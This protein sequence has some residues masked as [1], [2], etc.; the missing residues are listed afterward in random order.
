MELLLDT[1]ELSEIKDA[2]ENFPLAGITSN[3]SIVKKTAP[4]D[5]FAHMRE[6]RSIIGKEHT[7][8][9]Q[10]VAQDSET[11]LREAKRIFEEI[12][13]RVFIKVPVTWQGLRTIRILKEEGKNVTA[14][15]IYDIMQA[16][17]AMAAGADYLAVYVNRIAS[18]GGDPFELIR[19]TEE[20]IAMDEYSCKVLGASYHSVQQV[21]DSLN[22]GAQ[23]ITV[24][25]AY[26]RETY[27]NANIQGAVDQFTADFE[28]VYGK[29]KNLLD[30]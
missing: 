18:M 10:V 1:V 5:F 12:D 6:I 9:I 11:Q 20:R 17:Q 4:K 2:A 14:T 22:A 29:G 27:K 30:L 7:L 16:Y 15:A 23:S 26:F 13:D 25:I 19:L 3:P 24:P 28:A 8:H 21:R